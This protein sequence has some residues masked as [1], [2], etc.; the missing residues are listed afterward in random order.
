MHFNDHCQELNQQLDEIELNRD[1]FR[2]ALTEQINNSQMRVA[3]ERIDQWEQKSIDTIQRTAKECREKLLRHA[4][5]DCNEIEIG[6]MEFTDRLKATRREN[7][8]NEIDLKQ[9]KERLSTLQRRL[10]Q[11][12]NISI[13]QDSSSFIG[14]ISLVL[15]STGKQR[16]S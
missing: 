3:I 8:F 14:N 9:L 16:D 10:D 7:D 12:L 15:A 5:A 4:N 1:L 2:Q 6:L 13:Q 11:I